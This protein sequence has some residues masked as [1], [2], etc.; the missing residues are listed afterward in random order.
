MNLKIVMVLLLLVASS[1]A[2]KYKNDSNE[3]LYFKTNYPLFKIDVG[4]I[5]NTTSLMM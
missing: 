5:T 3:N 1:S 4:Q 2:Q